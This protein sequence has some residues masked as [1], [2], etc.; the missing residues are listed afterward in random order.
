MLDALLV[1]GAAKAAALAAPTL[2][3]AYDAVG[4]SRPRNA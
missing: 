3:Q 1:E 4:L 2:A